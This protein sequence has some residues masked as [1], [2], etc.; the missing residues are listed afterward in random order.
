MLR[1]RA[2]AIRALQPMASSALLKHNATALSRL[3]LMRA[4]HTPAN[5]GGTSRNFSV[6]GFPKILGKFVKV[7]A[8]FGSAVVGGAAYVQYKVQEA[9]NYTT[10]KFNQASDWVSDTFGSAKDA[11]NSLEF[12]TFEF[13][14]KGDQD[15]K[16]GSNSSQSSSSSSSAD[17]EPSGGGSEAATVAAVAATAA[18]SQEADEDQMMVLT[19]KMIEIRGILSQVDQS[20]TLQ[21][22]S[23]V[24]IGS[25][26]SGKSSVL[27]A[28]V[29]HEFLPKGSNMVTRRPIELTLI[30]TPDSAAEYGEFPSL[31]LGKITDFVQIQKTLAD[32]NLSVPDS[33]VVSDQPIQL[34][35][36]SPNVPDLTMIDL[37]GYIQ[38][39]AADQPDSLKHRISDLCE[40]YIQPPNV[41]LAISA[42]D[43]DLANSSA[44]RASK[45]VD[46]RG[47]R[48][49]GVITKMDLVDPQRGVSELLNKSYA[50]KMGYVG[51]IT[52]PPT[53]TGLFRRTSNI[54]SLVSQNEYNFFSQHPEYSDCT[55]GTIALRSK[56]MKVLE[57]TMAASL[58]PTAEA[59]S[60]ELEEAS[61]QFKVEYNDRE[62]TPQSYLAGS[63]DSFKL[64][65]KGLAN[66]LGR[67]EVK[68]LLRCEL[69]QK[70]LDILAQRYWN[71]PLSD[72]EKNSLLI[73]PALS[74]LPNAS[75]DDVFWHR[76]LDSCS[77]SLTKL[78]I[79]RVATNLVTS[80]LTF[81]MDNLVANSTFRNHPL[82]ANAIRDAT[83]DLLGMRFYSTADQVEN[84]IKPYKYEVEVDDRE[85]S[86]ARDHT[87]N[88]LREELRQCEDSMSALKKSIGN[89][90]LGQVMKY[91][92]A[93]RKSREGSVPPPQESE[94]AFGFS[95]ALIQKG[96]DAIFLRDRADILKMRMGAVKSRQCK[97]K[98]SKY[99]CPE[100]FLEVVADKLTQ[101]AVLFLNVELLSD[102]YYNFPRELDQRL[103]KLSEDQVN[104]FAK[105]D[106][107]IKRHIELQQRKE[108]LALAL[109][110]M[111]G[112]ME[113]QKVRDLSPRSIY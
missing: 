56:L 39:T 78:G 112:V 60:Q 6:G 17:G 53:Q 88:L 107:K 10:D 90:K 48:T 18:F 95:Q 63:V 70:V 58:R 73:E 47:E 94:V 84:C 40:K 65:F 54:T 57:Q 2:M 74:S 51:V 85:W 20:D 15:S 55:T 25:Q 93:I 36:Y 66:K 86:K 105:Q 67:E 111:Q 22:P 82:A 1:N 23:I 75:P 41:I 109:E 14:G 26:S 61:Y 31:G 50:L 32:L 81:E 30:N 33:D 80:A 97:S 104:V 87:Y 100:I 4:L 113:L 110:K 64:A 13:G 7:P 46:P 77:S 89:N 37:P 83:S 12:P 106:P 5:F 8:A 103:T 79:G 43:V 9:S 21:L 38:V 44:L 11:F 19:K 96:R 72:N 68:R 98:D 76:T 108:L 16:S 99:Y 101:T 34:H 49:I 24:V 69:D 27:E 3:R 92:E 59:I 28:I 52:R 29:G 91:V 102:F 45:R 62:L 42:A 71:K 35:I